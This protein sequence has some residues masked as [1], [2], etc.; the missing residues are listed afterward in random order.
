MRAQRPTDAAPAI[1]GRA[2]ALPLDDDSVDAAMA[3]FTVHHWQSARAGLDEL[4]R[5][6]RRRVVVA[7]FAIDAMPAWQRDYLREALAVEREA[8]PEVTEIAAA[9]RGRVRVEPIATPC[10]CVDGFIEAFWSRPEALLDARVRGSQSVWSRLAPGVQARIV[11]RL[12]EA[13]AC[14]EWDAAHGQLRDRPSF[15]GSLRLVVA[16]LDVED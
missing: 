9:L 13:L 12:R 6:A 5:V 3:C 15:D 16:E 10:D 8:F 1:I 14:G 11:T 4:Q 2:E 7:S